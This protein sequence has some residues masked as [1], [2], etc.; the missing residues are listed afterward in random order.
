[1]LNFIGK[2]EKTTGGALTLLV[3]CRCVGWRD[4]QGRS[5]STYVRSVARGLDSL[6][7]STDMCAFTP[8]KDHMPATCAPSASCRRS[9]SK[10]TFDHST[11]Q[12]IGMERWQQE[13]WSQTGEVEIINEDIHDVLLISNNMYV[14]TVST[15]IFFLNGSGY[16]PQKIMLWDF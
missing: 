8:G 14:C 4:W 12:P 9:T 5:L 6:H 10:A 3:S 2:D 1:M 13:D 11:T 16:S 15:G 7:T